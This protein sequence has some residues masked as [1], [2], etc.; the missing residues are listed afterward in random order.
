MTTLILLR[1]PVSPIGPLARA[2]AALETSSPLSEPVAEWPP[3]VH[4]RN[5]E[6]PARQWMGD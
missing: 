3:A 5:G 2:T 1:I 6:G 4:R